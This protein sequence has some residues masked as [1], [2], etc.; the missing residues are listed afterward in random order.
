MVL[1]LGKKR[2]G[3]KSP[4]RSSSYSRKVRI[5]DHLGQ[6]GLG[7]GPAVA[8]GGEGTFN[9]ATAQVHG[10]GHASA[11]WPTHSF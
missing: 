1:P 3:R 10:Q 8:T 7:Y 11:P 4:L 2:R 9:V 6:Q 5:N